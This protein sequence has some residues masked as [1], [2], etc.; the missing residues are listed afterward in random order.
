MRAAAADPAVRAALDLFGGSLVNVE[1]VR[2][3]PRT[4]E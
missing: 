4:K 1:P 3:E 2:L